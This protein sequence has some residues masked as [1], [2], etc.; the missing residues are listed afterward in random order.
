VLG[1]SH[2]AN[3]GVSGNIL[4]VRFN[5]IMLPDSTSDYEGSMGYFQY[6]LKPLPNLPN[7]SQIRNTAYIYFDYN[8][9]IVTNTT[10]NNFDIT[11]PVKSLVYTEN[12]FSLYPNP[13]TGVFIFK[14]TKNVNS[15][16]VYSIV[17]EKILSQTNQKTINLNGF[18]K[19][20]YFARV[21]GGVVLKMVKE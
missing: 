1:Y 6:R 10:E 15:V 17:G 21:N 16:E 5:N 8:A 3:V 20:I 13:S 9:P 11:V 4:T 12:S 7:G 19:G 2:P 18:S 14:D